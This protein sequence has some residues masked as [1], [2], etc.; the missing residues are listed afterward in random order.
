MSVCYDKIHKILTLSQS[1]Y[2]EQLLLKFNLAD[3]KSVDTPMECGLK[4]TKAMSSDKNLP[5]Q[6]LIGC[7]IYVAILTRPDIAFIC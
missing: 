5:Y 1:N 6:Q 4:L 2:I 7:L 3:C